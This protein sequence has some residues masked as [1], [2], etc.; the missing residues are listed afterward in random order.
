M[1]KWIGCMERLEMKYAAEKLGCFS[2]RPSLPEHNCR[3]SNI[4]KHIIEAAT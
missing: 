1:L 2:T 3:K 4:N